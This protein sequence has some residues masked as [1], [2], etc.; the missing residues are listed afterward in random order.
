MYKNL[1]VVLL[2]IYILDDNVVTLSHVLWNER[3][4]FYLIFSNTSPIFK[5]G[6]YEVK[7]DCVMS[8]QDLDLLL[9]QAGVYSEMATN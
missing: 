2:I 7:H 6:E 9:S 5:N 3:K 1:S 8:L 4:A